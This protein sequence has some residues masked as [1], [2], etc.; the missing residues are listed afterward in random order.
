[1]KK[2]RGR[3]NCSC[4]SAAHVNYISVTRRAI[5][6]NLCRGSIE[7]VHEQRQGAV[8]RSM[9]SACAAG[10]PWAPSRLQKATDLPLAVGWSGSDGVNK[11]LCFATSSNRRSAHRFA[12]WSA[13]LRLSLSRTLGTVL[14]LQFLYAHVLNC[15]FSNIRHFDPSYC[16]RST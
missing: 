12:T 5:F 3:E 13:G 6:L 10:G 4:C 7:P 8:R 15:I 11:V 9:P 14:G 1:M 16:A 2:T